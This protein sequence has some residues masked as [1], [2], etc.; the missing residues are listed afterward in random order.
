MLYILTLA[1]MKAELGITDN[2]DNALLTAWLEGLQG[3][4]DTHLN[5]RLLRGENTVELFDGGGTWVRPQG[6]P[7]ESVASLHVDTDQEWDADSLIASDD[8]RINLKR[9]LVYYTVTPGTKFPEGLQ[10]VRVVSTGGYVST[11]T[12]ATAT[13]FAMPEDIRRCMRL[14]A[15]FEWRNRTSLGKE[16]FSAGGASMSIAPAELLPEV[17]HG[18]APYMAL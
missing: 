2:A 4:F 9:G 8:Y 11:G 14:Q 13:Q 18:L 7:L 16:S 3:R 12:A 15:G 10:N 6:W 17:K 1:E 5:R